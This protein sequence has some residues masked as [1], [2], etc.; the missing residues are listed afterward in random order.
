MAWARAWRHMAG[1][2]RWWQAGGRMHRERTGIAVHGCSNRGCMRMAPQ[3]LTLLSCMSG[4]ISSAGQPCLGTPSRANTR[5]SSDERSSSA[6]SGRGL[7]ASRF[8]GAGVW[9][10]SLSLPASEER[11]R[12]PPLVVS[13]AAETAMASSTA[14]LSSLSSPSNLRVAILPLSVPSIATPLWHQPLWLTPSHRI[15]RRSSGSRR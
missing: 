2:H 7:K 3:S 11:A 14:P 1:L 6:A 8:S 15:R 12:Q 10:R 5:G 9:A 4:S 13:P